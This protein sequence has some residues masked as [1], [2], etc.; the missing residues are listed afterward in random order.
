MVVRLGTASEPAATAATGFGAGAGCRS[1]R[2]ARTACRR[3]GRQVGEEIYFNAVETL[4]KSL[5]T[6]V[7]TWNTVAAMT[8]EIPE[9]ISAYSI[10]VAALSSRAKRRS[11]PAPKNVDRLFMMLCTF[12]SQQ[13]Y[14]MWNQGL[15]GRRHRIVAEI[16][17]ARQL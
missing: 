6:A 16:F 14:Q 17:W 9:A 12:P 4:V 3:E 5:L 7:P 10:A 1:P 13:I 8:M 11:N 15:V 2:H